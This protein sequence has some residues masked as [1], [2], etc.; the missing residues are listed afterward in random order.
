MKKLLIISFSIFYFLVAC[1]ISVS[2]HYCGN[3]LKEVS[4]TQELDDC[5]CSKMKNSHCCKD[6]SYAFK[7]KDTQEL[8]T[9]ETLSQPDS[10]ELLISPVSIQVHLEKLVIDLFSL[11]DCNAPPYPDPGKI[12]LHNRSFR[13]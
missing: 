10:K 1:G 13:I 2:L 9:K 5:C 12:Y 3:R 7:L 6:K 11:P 8:A 4:F